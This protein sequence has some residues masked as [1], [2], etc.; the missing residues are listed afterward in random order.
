M[1]ALAISKKLKAQ[2]TFLGSNLKVYENII[3]DTINCI[4]L[5]MDIAGFHDPEFENNTTIDVLHYAPLNVSGIRL[6]NKII[7]DFFNSSYQLILIVDISVEVTL[8]AR[9]CGIPTI[10][11][12]QHGYR[13]DPAHLAAYQSASLIIAPYPIELRGA[14]PNWVDEKTLFT[15]GFSKY[16]DRVKS[17]KT[18]ISNHIAI[19]I[20]TGGT[21]IDRKF[22]VHLG[23][24]YPDFYFHVIGDVEDTNN[25]PENLN[26]H[27]IMAEPLPVLDMC[28]VVIGNAGHNTV[29][30]M[31]DLQKSFICI[32]EPRPFDEQV[33]KALK[34]AKTFKVPIIKP[35]DIFSTDWG[36]I[37]NDLIAEPI[38]WNGMIHR[39]AIE[40][41]TTEIAILEKKVFKLN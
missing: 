2:V 33:D 5:P 32:P 18:A 8:L 7:C 14:S 30:E 29:M 17:G 20:G 6:R 23:F 27:G 24:N 1:R 19:I 4:H 31:A 36:F 34:I 39:N 38:Q 10:V 15:G 26:F 25:L 22:L 35:G 13:E 3:P 37:I 9:L 40:Q 21:C 11:I 28:A 41:I 16:S 12:K